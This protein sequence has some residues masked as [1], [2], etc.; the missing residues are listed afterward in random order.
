MVLKHFSMK[1]EA[2]QIRAALE[3][4]PAGLRERVTLLI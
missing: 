2:R 1:Y 3:T 4:L